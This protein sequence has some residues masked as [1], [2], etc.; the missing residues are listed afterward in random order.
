MNNEVF[1]TGREGFVGTWL[2]RELK[3]HG[4]SVSGTSHRHYPEGEK[5]NIFHCD[6]TNAEQIG[7]LIS[8]RQPH[9]IV[10]LAALVKPA[11]AIKNPALALKI[12]VDG[13]RN[14][15]ESVRAVPGYH[16]RVII[17][18]SAEEFGVVPSD[19]TINEETSLLPVN[20]YGESKML[21]WKLA[22]E[23]V[24]DYHLDI[25]SAIPFNH[26]GPGQALGFLAPDVA[27][28]IVEIEKGF[29]EP[30]LVTGNISHKRN[31]SDVRDVARAY[32]LLL[33]SGRAGERYIV[34]AD[35]SVPLS[36]IVTTLI[37]MSSVKIEHQ[38]DPNRARIEDIADFTAS[39]AK[40]TR[41]TG[42]VPEIP[43]E[44]TLKDLLDWYR[45]KGKI[46]K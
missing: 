11:D 38:I 43:L 31:F 7:K 44:Q 22:E 29:K 8:D 19:I 26:T 16:P 34:C 9:F 36:Y 4:Y 30:I 35:K 17:I 37:G 5:D 24:R 21:A 42:W 27:A 25:V 10:H 14:I 28:Q 18:G 13:T 6:I 12:N 23:Y 33:E 46:E 3:S 1:I 41:E 20:P 15:F 2:S 40:I 39:H 45:R 32:R